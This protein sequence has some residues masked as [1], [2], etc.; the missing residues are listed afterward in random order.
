M[1]LTQFCQQLKEAIEPEDSLVRIVESLKILSKL[2]LCKITNCINDLKERNNAGKD[3]AVLKKLIVIQVHLIQSGFNKRGI[4]QT[5]PGENVTDHTVFLG[6][7]GYDIAVQSVNFW[8]NLGKSANGLH[9]H[10]IVSG[11][12][13]NF[14]NEHVIP[15]IKTIE[16]MGTIA[17]SIAV[18]I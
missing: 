4:N 3:D 14:I 8:K 6:G 15:I 2:R 7:N 11:Q 17:Q 13:K 16:E 18:A 10:K 1:T 9:V 5:R 12:A